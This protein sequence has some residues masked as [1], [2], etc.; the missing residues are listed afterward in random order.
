[1]KQ[2]TAELRPVFDARKQVL[3]RLSEA[4]ELRCSNRP[5]RHPKRTALTV[6]EAIGPALAF[7][8]A[9]ATHR[10]PVTCRVT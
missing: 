10:S 7:E 4:S 2:R 6:H 5:L 8:V 1:M 3:G 9:H